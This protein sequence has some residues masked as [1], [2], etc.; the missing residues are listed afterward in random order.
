MQKLKTEMEY[1]V[2]KIVF[3]TLA[4]EQATLSVL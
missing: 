4:A 2:A 3:N 1:G